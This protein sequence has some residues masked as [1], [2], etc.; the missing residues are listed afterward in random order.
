MS[1]RTRLAQGRATA[2][3]QPRPQGERPEAFDLW[4]RRELDS[5]YGKVEDEALSPELEE[6][7]GR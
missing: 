5:I 4:L 7:L 6:L 1:C 2:L 3:S